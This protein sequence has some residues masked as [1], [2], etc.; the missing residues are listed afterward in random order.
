MGEI[1]AR[2]TGYTHCDKLVFRTQH[3]GEMKISTVAFD[4]VALRDA[5]SPRNR[6]VKE[7]GEVVDEY[8]TVTVEPARKEEHFLEVIMSSVNPSSNIFLD[9]N[10][11]EKYLEQ[12]APLPLNTSSVSVL[13]RL[14]L[15]RG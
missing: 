11:V 15:F 2:R 7:L 13:L 4:A 10:A 6:E 1:R 14:A 12:V 3:Y 8:A 5:M 9:Q